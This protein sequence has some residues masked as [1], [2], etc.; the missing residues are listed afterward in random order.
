MVLV[1]KRV[2]CFVILFVCYVFCLISF[3][4]L[5]LVCEVDL[6]VCFGQC[7]LRVVLLVHWLFVFRV[8]LACL[9]VCLLLLFAWL[10]VCVV[11]GFCFL[12]GLGAVGL[13]F[14]CG[15]DGCLGFVCFCLVL[16]VCFT[17]CC[18][19]VCFDCC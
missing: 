10:L 8:V 2:F 19:L 11:F 6:V 14:V 12:F 1:F 16:G 17:V 18:W 4:V 15:D 5:R 13:L 9:C 3:G 7:G